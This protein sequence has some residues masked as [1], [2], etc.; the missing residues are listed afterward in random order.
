LEKTKEII[1]KIN[2]G[3]IKIKIIDGLSPL[4][5]LGL[6]HQFSEVM[7]PK[8]P[9]GEIFNAFRRRLLATRVRLLCA[10][11]GEYNLVKAV[12][13]VDEQ[14]ECPKCSSRLMA[15][16][17]RGRINAAEL[18][19]KKL[20]KKELTKEEMAEFQSIRRSADLVIVYGKKAVICLA[21][22]GIGPQT[23]ARILAS[24]HPTKEAMLKD[25]L[26]A[27][28]QFIKTKPYWK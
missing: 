23:A 28:K 8:L 24:L 2:E 4:G 25:I 13:E 14:P 10:N 3:E 6:V 19:K 15:I 20:K 9:E 5:E 22:H 21:G 27:E 16:I 26:A 18:V 7:K 17:S 1:E 11:C 12:K